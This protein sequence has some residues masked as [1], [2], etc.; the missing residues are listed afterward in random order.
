MERMLGQIF[1]DL[2]ILKV[3]INN[4]GK[5]LRAQSTFNKLVGLELVLLSVMVVGAA[6]HCID[7]RE[8]IE[9]LK[10]EIEMLKESK[11]E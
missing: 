5:T 3:D 2:H 1:A 4:V 11:G 7:N 8:K 6:K 9:E 10:K